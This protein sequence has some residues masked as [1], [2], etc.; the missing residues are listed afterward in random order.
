MK[1]ETT[2][3]IDPGRTLCLIENPRIQE[4]I[5]VLVEE[6]EEDYF[7]SSLKECMVC[8]HG[9]DRDETINL[10]CQLKNLMERLRHIHQRIVIL[11]QNHHNCSQDNHT[12]SAKG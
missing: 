4:A 11:R 12:S 7:L 2:S 9:L 5:A 6:L 10:H 3:P 8:H 1:R